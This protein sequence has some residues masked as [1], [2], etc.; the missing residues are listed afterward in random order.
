M[1]H[2]VSSSNEDAVTYCLCRSDG[3]DGIL[4]M[5]NGWMCAILACNSR[6]VLGIC[7]GSEWVSDDRIEA[8]GFYAFGGCACVQHV[9]F[10]VI[11]TCPELPP[12]GG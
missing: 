1:T 3:G 8:G 12:A 5:L 2:T 4:A 10:T 6:H 9:P 11:V 7:C